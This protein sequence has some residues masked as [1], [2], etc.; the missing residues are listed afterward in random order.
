M[1]TQR[2]KGVFVIQTA[3]PEHPVYRAL[4]TYEGQEGSETLKAFERELLAERAEFGYP[5]YTRIIDITG[6]D[7]SETRVEKMSRELAAVLSGYNVTGPYTPV[8]VKSDGEYVRKLRITLAKDRQLTEN[9]ERLLE[10]IRKYESSSRY[11]GHFTIDV[12]PS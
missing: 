12:D 9:K 7:I 5:P 8:T 4:S 3:Q 11:T 6:R 2:G 10:I 1:R